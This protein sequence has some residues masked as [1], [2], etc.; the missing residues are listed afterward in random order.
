MPGPIDDGRD[1]DLALRQLCLAGEQ[2][3]DLGLEGFL[4]DQLARVDPVDLG[5]ERGDPVLVGARLIDLSL[6]H[7]GHQVVAEKGIGRGADV[8]DGEDR[9][10]NDAAD[11]HRRVDLES[12]DRVAGRDRDARRIRAL[13]EAADALL[14]LFPVGA[15]P[16]AVH[17]A[18]TPYCLRA[19]VARRRLDHRRLG[20][21]ICYG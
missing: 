14:G 12:P 1:V 21:S 2:R 6:D 7:A 20:V 17:V 10:R 15:V 9:H 5:A 4:I 19:G 8:D 11:D 16:G 18:P 3:V 13:A